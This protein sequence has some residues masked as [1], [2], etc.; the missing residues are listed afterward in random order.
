MSEN[1]SFG[2]WLHQRRRQLDLTQQELANQIGCARI[3]L[4]R[5]EAG[6]LKPSKELALI[7]LE[8]LG[9]PKQEQLQ[10]LQFA[11]GL[12]GYPIEFS[13]FPT[14]GPLTN[15]PF[16]LTSFIGREKEKEEVKKSY[17]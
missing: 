1:V 11:R 14:K 9:I 6:T 5:I 3:T 12:T 4:S 8:R 17:K 10:W 7:L 2:R 13:D 15:L 16:H